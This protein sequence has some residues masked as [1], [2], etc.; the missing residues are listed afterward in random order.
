[1]SGYFPRGGDSGRDAYSHNIISSGDEFQEL[2]HY[3]KRH[4]KEKRKSSKLRKAKNKTALRRRLQSLNQSDASVE[5]ALANDEDD[6]GALGSSDDSDN[7]DE[8][9]RAFA[10]SGVARKSASAMVKAN[11]HSLSSQI[12]QAGRYLSKSLSPKGSN[13]LRSILSHGRRQSTEKVRFNPQVDQRSPSPFV[14]QNPELDEILAQGFDGEFVHIS[15]D[16]DLADEDDDAVYAK[17]QEMISESDVE[18]PDEQQ[19]EDLET[20]YLIEH[21]RENNELPGGEGAFS[22]HYSLTQ[23]AKSDVTNFEEPDFVLP[24]TE[25]P[26]NDPSISNDTGAPFGGPLTTSPIDMENATD[27]LSQYSEAF[28]YKMEPLETGLQTPSSL[29]QSYGMPEY[30]DED[31]E[32]EEPK[33]VNVT[34]AR[35]KRISGHGL[36]KSSESSGVRKNSKPKTPKRGS[37]KLKRSSVV[38]QHDAEGELV[39]SKAG[40]TAHSGTIT[41]R[42]TLTSDSKRQ[43]PL[44]AIK[45]I[46]MADSF[47]QAM[48]APSSALTSPATESVFFPETPLHESPLLSSAFGLSPQLPFQQE[49]RFQDIIVVKDD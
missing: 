31:T 49:L 6:D 13:K 9:P 11:R 29:P 42:G 22:E 45:P 23:S 25:F 15:D 4:F 26:L 20:Q 12:R 30:D 33:V 17:L 5:D 1:M 39:I 34:A 46:P 43:K 40:K 8:K 36:P 21:L 32:P 2:S 47:I 38:I 14:Q 41:P 35:L 24:S 7:D 28:G 19:M 44:D 48:T 18:D 10:P 27:I 3:S 37:F 16:E